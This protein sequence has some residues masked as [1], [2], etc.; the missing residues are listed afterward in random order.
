MSKIFNNLKN[1]Q[2]SILKMVQPKG[3]KCPEC[4]TTYEKGA[5]LRVDTGMKCGACAYGNG[6]NGGYVSRTTTEGLEMRAENQ[7]E[8]EEEPKPFDDFRADE[9]DFVK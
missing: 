5:D 6:G 4:D 1:L 3:N 8:D 7:E 9:N 2:N